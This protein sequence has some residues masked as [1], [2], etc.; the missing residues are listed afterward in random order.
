MAKN[1]G[2]LK[3]WARR[4]FLEYNLPRVG[5]VFD[6]FV[7]RGV[8]KRRKGGCSCED[9]KILALKIYLFYVNLA[10]MMH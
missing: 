3:K 7:A 2:G 4:F 10:D 9:A 1:I 5:Y 8:G 6:I